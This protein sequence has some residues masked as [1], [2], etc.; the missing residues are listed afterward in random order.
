[1]RLGVSVCWAPVPEIM[2]KLDTIMG[3]SKGNAAACKNKLKE[4]TEANENF[5]KGSVLQMRLNMVQTYTKQF[6]E[7]TR[8]LTDTLP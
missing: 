6:A 3:D 5:K 7:S 1:M 8:K 4:I 2:R